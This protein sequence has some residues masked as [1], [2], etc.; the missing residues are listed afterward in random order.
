[1][2]KL[3]LPTSDHATV[4]AACL[5]G[6]GSPA[7]VAHYTHNYSDCAVLELDYAQRAQASVLYA[8]PRV[9]VPRGTD[10]IVLNALRRSE[11]TKLYTEYL[12]PKSKPGRVHYDRLKV[13]SN[14]KCPLCG[15]LGQVRTL[16]HYLPKANFPLY[17]IV[18]ANLIP[19]CRDC[20]S[21]KLAGFASVANRQT[22]HPYFDNNRFFTER[23]LS[24]RV[25]PGTPPVLEYSVTP[26]AGWSAAD[27]GRVVAH[28]EEYDLAKRFSIEA[29]ADLPET[30]Q[31][32]ITESALL[33]PAE[34]SVQLREKSDE[35]PLSINHWRRVMFAALA[36]DAWFCSYAH[37][38]PVV[39]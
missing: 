5:Q 37:P 38:P 24:A 39:T 9:T 36:S 12:V 8:L 34:F 35:L 17:S 29:G 3:P 15:D 21:E 2:K 7:L 13:T 20:N 23:W 1:M 19:C 26:P 30:I 16:D 25:V 27:R 11:L 28:F 10:P 14:G 6:I 4:F 22:L 32:R 18:P 33:S 31:M